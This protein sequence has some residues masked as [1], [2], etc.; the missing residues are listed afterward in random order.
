MNCLKRLTPSPT[1]VLLAFILFRLTC[2]AQIRLPAIIGDNMVLQADTEVNLWGWA[3]PDSNVVVTCSWL[4]NS[5][6]CQSDEKGKWKT[7]IKTP[8]ATTDT[9]Q[10]TIADG[11]DKIVIN[12]ILF[13]QVWI[14]S[15]QSNMQWI[16]KRSVNADHEIAS[17]NYPDIRLFTVGAKASEVP[18]DD[19]EGKW[20]ICSPDTVPWF[21]AVGYFFGRELHN[22]LKVPIGLIN[23]SWGGTP[24]EAWTKKEVLERDKDFD[25]YIQRDKEWRE[26]R[27]KYQKRYD[28]TIEKWKS[29]IEKA[30]SESRIPP[31]KPYP[32][33][34]LSPQKNCSALY[35]G[36]IHPL[37][38]YTIK[39]AIWY[40]GESNTSMAYLYHKLFS[41]M[42]NNWRNDW[43]QGNFPFYFVQLAN[44][45]KH[46]PE[47]RP[48]KLPEIGEPKDSYWAELR[49]AQLM[50]LSLPNTGLAVTMDIGDPYDIHPKN[51]QDVGKRLSLW[52][53]AKDCGFEDIVYSG[54]IYKS[55]KI[56]GNKIR[57]FFD[58]IGSS[59]YSKGDKLRGFAIAGQDGKLVWAKAEIDGDSVI[60]SSDEI[61][62][63]KAVRY[64]WLDWIECN[65]FNKEGLPASPFRTDD[66]PGIT[67]SS[68][69]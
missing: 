7:K 54:P 44:F 47:D 46:T 37:I 28:E 40:Q 51:K 50:T 38:P 22:K 9:F 45:Y 1:C 12:N 52:V 42:I 56:E 10:I 2:Y 5:V 16:V 67:N 43:K 13:G 64:G 18:L 63:P 17:A 69:K 3:G 33:G 62:E 6:S 36:M 29:D 66:W 60:V 15:G 61:S 25:Y 57:L 19:V 32:P 53:L 20:R 14:C 48:E 35:N 55:M 49:E 65:L 23:S 26:N 68:N 59:L 31:G 21:S 27:D 4:Y 58:H 8:P 24:A 11:D 39:G 30:K 34:A 41:A